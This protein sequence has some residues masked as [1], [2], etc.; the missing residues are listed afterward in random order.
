ME[1]FHSIGRG[2][3][4]SRPVMY[5]VVASG[6]SSPIPVLDSPAVV[7]AGV[8]VIL[9]ST[10]Q[11]A[12]PLALQWW[13]NGRPIDGATNAEVRLPSVNRP[14]EGFYSL[15]VSNALGTAS[16]GPTPM[17][18]ANRSPSSLTSLIV[19]EPAGTAV[20][21]AYSDVLGDVVTWRPL[22]NLILNISPF[23]V[24]DPGSV[25]VATRFYRVPRSLKVSAQRYSG[26][27]YMDPPGSV[28]QVEVIDTRVGAA[29]WTPLT[30]ITITNSPFQFVDTSTSQSAFRHYRSTVL[31]SPASRRVGRLTFSVRWI[32]PADLFDALKPEDR[33]GL[34]SHGVTLD[35]TQHALV[36]QT[37]G[38][39]GY[40]IVMGDQRV[41]TDTNG[42]FA[43]DIPYGMTNGY[44]VSR[45]GEPHTHAELTFSANQLSEPGQPVVPLVLQYQH[46]GEFDMDDP[47]A[48]V[49][50]QSRARLADIICGNP[51]VRVGNSTACCLD[52]NGYIPTD[53]KGKRELEV[54]ITHYIGSTCHKL[55]T[56]GLCAREWNALQFV[57]VPFPPFVIPFAPLSGPSCFVN[58]RYRNCQNIDNSFSI[59]PDVNEITSGGTFT[60][61]VHNNTWA[62]ETILTV[63]EGDLT[64]DQLVASASPR[65]RELQHWTESPS[66][67]HLEDCTITFVDSKKSP[68]GTVFT[69]LGEAAG[70]RISAQVSIKGV[71]TN[72]VI[73]L[74]AQ[75]AGSNWDLPAVIQLTPS[76]SGIRNFTGSNNKP[77]RG[78]PFFSTAPTLAGATFYPCNLV[79]GFPRRL[80][81]NSPF[82][83]RTGGSSFIA[84]LKHTNSEPEIWINASTGAFQISGQVTANWE[85]QVRY[86]SGNTA[87][88]VPPSLTIGTVPNADTYTGTP[89]TSFDVK[90][91]YAGIP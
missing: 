23:I 30:I 80:S 87:R 83:N 22:T 74:P 67:E 45:P 3:A 57:S 28:H 27:T 32:L 38:M 63:P 9:R 68:P 5:A 15:S 11:G 59:T 41:M 6:I 70:N 66:R 55:V 76:L 12:P 14:E 90:V 71:L 40:W 1:G 60:L 47:L 54:A 77:E 36:M 52:Y 25:G 88:G 20:D 4:N 82:P 75:S 61:K 81:G 73:R 21:I 26:W 43:I 2:R 78:S 72:I 65:Q 56:A 8:D 49:S 42:N 7:D 10:V 18:I 91:D 53:C 34:T 19:E 84:V 29:Q 37:N 44:V 31:Q 39:P 24:V 16:T 64:G 13:F 85:Y 17:L 69:F 50:T 35:D 51:A 62:N 46:S 79:T 33:I 58:H 86:Y 48:A 89:L